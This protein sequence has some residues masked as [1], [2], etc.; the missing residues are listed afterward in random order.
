[1]VHFD[2]NP[3][4]A[5]IVHV[6]LLISCLLEITV[7]LG[8]HEFDAIASH[9]GLAVFA[10]GSLLSKYNKVVDYKKKFLAS[11]DKGSN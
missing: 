4:L 11:R 9:H 5:F 8:F 10:L 1:M 3:L 2:E 7:E 6:I